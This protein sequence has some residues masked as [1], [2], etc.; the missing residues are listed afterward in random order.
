[1]IQPHGD[2]SLPRSGWLHPGHSVDRSA[3]RSREKRSNTLDVLR[4]HARMTHTMVARPHQAVSQ[5]GTVQGGQALLTRKV[6]RVSFHMPRFESAVSDILT[7]PPA[8]VVQARRIPLQLSLFE[9]PVLCCACY[10]LQTAKGKWTRSALRASDYPQVEFSHG[11]CA[12]CMKKLYP[13]LFKS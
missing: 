2:L 10:R 1:M 7:P 8:G 13:N 6:R 11:I 5:T 9:L 3:A 4:T 12:R